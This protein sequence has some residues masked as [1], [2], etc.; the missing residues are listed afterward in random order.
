MGGTLI[1][2][3][4]DE[5]Q[6]LIAPARIKEMAQLGQDSGLDLGPVTVVTR[7]EFDDEFCSRDEGFTDQFERCI[8]VI[9]PGTS[10]EDIV[11]AVFQYL[12]RFQ[13]SRHRPGEPRMYLLAQSGDEWRLSLHLLQGDSD[14]VAIWRP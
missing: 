3:P 6:E 5:A 2:Y 13:G 8:L 1:V 10:I 4:N 11:Q 9:A 14:L 12:V 7:Q